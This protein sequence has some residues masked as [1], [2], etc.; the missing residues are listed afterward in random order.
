MGESTACWSSAH[1]TCTFWPQSQ[2]N[3]ASPSRKRI[4]VGEIAPLVV[5]WEQNVGNK[6]KVIVTGAGGGLEILNC[7]RAKRGAK[8]VVNDLGGSSRVKEVTQSC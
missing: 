2:A 1:V 4:K 5:S 7:L 6:D 8:V 3:P